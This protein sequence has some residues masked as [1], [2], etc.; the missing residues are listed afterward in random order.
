[1]PVEVSDD[2][3]ERL[4]RDF[5][6]F[7]DRR[8]V[9]CCSF[10]ADWPTWKIHPAGDEIVCVLSGEARLVLD[11]GER[12]EEIALD[13]PFAFAIVPRNTWHTAR[14]ESPCTMLLITPGE[15]TEKKVVEADAD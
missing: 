11:Y 1:M 14:I 8:L 5:D 13:E 10:D 2:L 3:Y 15:G 6:G 9:S 4:E 12:L 7:T